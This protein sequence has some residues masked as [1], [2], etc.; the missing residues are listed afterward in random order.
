MLK[1]H[2]GCGK[3]YIQGWIN[4]DLTYKYQVDKVWDLT[5]PYPPFE[6]GSVDFIFIEHVLE[7]FT[8]KQGIKILKT[9]NSL[10]KKG[11]VL[12]VVVPSLE[13]LVKGY[14]EDENY[15]DLYNELNPDAK[16]AFSAQLINKA[17]YGYGHKNMY[18]RQLLSFALKS[19]GFSFRDM[20]FFA[21]DSV[22]DV[23]F[24]GLGRRKYKVNSSVQNLSVEVKRS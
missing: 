16:I 2:V 17:F 19:A 23:V 14:L 1:V 20:T 12:R 18:D 13:S 15:R 24:H 8:L 7:H 22:G 3:N 21:D 11:G 4:C 6:V 10:L 5:S 9:F